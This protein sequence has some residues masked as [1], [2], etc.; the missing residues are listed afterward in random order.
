MNIFN[1]IIQRFGV[2]VSDPSAQALI[3]LIPS[4]KLGSQSDGSQYAISKEAG[5]DLLFQ[6][7]WDN[8]KRTRP[9]T[10]LLVGA[11][12]FSEGADRHKAYT[13]FLPFDF[14]FLD[15]RNSLRAKLLPTKS[16]VIGQ[17][18]VPSDHPSTDWDRWV[19][20]DFQLTATYCDSGKVHDFLV[21]PPSA[22]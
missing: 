6:D 4:C 10:R 20:R 21:A 15:D 9:E 7:R 1:E 22:A 19:S 13:G 2:A 8:D 16:W 3:A 12:F 18:A 14:S 17:G 11:F 5:I